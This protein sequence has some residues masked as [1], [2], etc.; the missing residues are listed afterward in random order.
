MNISIVVHSKT[1]N[2]LLVANSLSDRL[3]SEGHTVSLANITAEND[4]EA[5]VDAIVLTNAPQVAEYDLLILGAPVR[6][7][8]LS[9][10]MQ[11]YL[12]QLKLIPGKPIYGFVTQFFP[13]PK[14]GG[15]QAIQCMSE[16]C[17]SKGN[18]LGATGVINWMFS[19]KR[20]NQIS[21]TVDKFTINCRC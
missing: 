7:G 10:V 16:I 3:K 14:L 5:N 19:A 13:S 11:A 18:E 21:E 2:T 1:G 15:N 17:S 6:G 12:R 20:N 9:P 4:S 8:R